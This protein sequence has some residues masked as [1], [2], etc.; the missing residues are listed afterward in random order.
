MKLLFFGD[1]AVPDDESYDSI[2]K[3]IINNNLFKDKLVI[4]NLEGLIV[5]EQNTLKKYPKQ[6]FNTEKTLKLF[7][8]TKYTV[9]TLANNHIKDIPNNFNMTISKLKN[10]KIGYTGAG[11]NYEEACKPHEFEIENKNY[12]VFSHCWNVM[13]KIME[14]KS[15]EIYANDMQYEKLI[16][17]I[18]KYKEAHMD[19]I[20][21][22]FLHWN[23][24]YETLPF[25]SH[26]VIAKK[27][28]DM[29]VNYVI[30]GHS[31]VINGGEKYKD[32]II[33]YGMGNF[34]IPSNKFFG[35]NLRY[36]GESA[37]QIIIEI[38]D[39]TNEI[40]YYYID[41]K[42]TIKE[43]FDNGSI[44][45]KYSPY[46]NMNEKDYVKYFKKNRV[47]KII[48]PVYKDEK[49]NIINHMKD[50]IVI[51]RMRLFRTLKNVK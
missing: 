41:D 21:I 40:I 32:G 25:P 8:D 2:R 46:R 28:I 11:L 35:G 33:V 1:M 36:T 22:V 7:K 18:K 20:V 12:A 49:N 44:I 29:G 50:T 10:N 17:D 24:D 15:N 45:K 5:N 37:K 9:L 43:D 31:H 3:L 38:D 14:K 39:V 42:G 16:Y 47:K 4:G 23:F 51:N 48:I 27:L 26:R 13:S 19:T 6:L 34:C 30:G